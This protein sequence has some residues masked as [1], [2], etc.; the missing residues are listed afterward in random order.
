MNGTGNAHCPVEN[1]ETSMSRDRRTPTDRPEGQAQGSLLEQDSQTRELTA[2]AL[3]GDSE[4]FESLIRVYAR[5][6]YAQTFMVLGDHG[7]TEDAVQETFVRA[8]RFR[9]QL[10]DPRL[11]TFWLLSIARNVARDAL[12]KRPR[13][14]LVAAEQA[15]GVPDRRCR[16]PLRH[17]EATDDMQRL[18][19]ALADL[20]ARYRLAL[21]LRYVEGLDHR[22]IERKMNISNGALRGVLVRGLRMLR[23]EL[24][25]DA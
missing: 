21:N 3:A 7:E 11:F 14:A 12:R 8:Y 19:V 2:K 24:R 13:A 18:G 22:T 15:R 9:V 5:L 10:R 4:A 25:A 6:V 1:L 23:R 20:P 17:A 16:S